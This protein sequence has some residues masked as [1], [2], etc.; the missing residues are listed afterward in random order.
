MAG[1][2][3]KI[4]YTGAE[5]SCL[6]LA[7]STAKTLTSKIGAVGAEAEDPSFGVAGVLD[8][9]AAANDALSKLAAVIDAYVD[10][11]CEILYGDDEIETGNVLDSESQAKGTD[12]YVLFAIDSVL[13]SHA[14][15]SWEFAKEI[16][17]LDDDEQTLFERLINGASATANRI[18]RRIFAATD[19]TK[20]LD[21]N[22]SPAL[23]LP[24]YP[25]NEITELNID[26]A[27]E[28]GADTVETAY[29]LY[30]EH[31]ELRLKYG[32]FP[33]CPQCVKV[34]FNA[35]YADVPDE[36][37]LAVLEVVAFN[38]SRMINRG[39]R[40]GTKSFQADGAIS[41]SYELTVPMNARVVFEYYGQRL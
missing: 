38:A 27:W 40:I 15:V 4:R 23:L 20:T 21:G 30:A 1:G 5:D 31:G 35:G 16:L 34:V 37:Q 26:V 25:V 14:L 11:T 13:A 29:L 28:F 10:Y 39:N 7:D 18:G 9:T 24:E 22:G 36:L 12:A 6:L 33:E 32:E 17:E 8:L 41:T 19:Y 3:L 2:A